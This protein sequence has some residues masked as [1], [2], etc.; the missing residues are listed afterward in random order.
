LFS[1]KH[2]LTPRPLFLAGR[3][4]LSTVCHCSL[5]HFSLLSTSER[6]LH[7]QTKDAGVYS[8]SYNKK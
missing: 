1:G 2:L 6:H 3:P 5:I 7:P 4:Y 8:P